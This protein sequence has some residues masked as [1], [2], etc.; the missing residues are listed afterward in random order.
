MVNQ[1]WQSVDA[2]L[3]G[4]SVTETIVWCEIINLN[5]IIFECSKNYI[6]STPATRLKIA[7]NMAD[8]ISVHE[9]GP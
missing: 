9:N 4:V 8:P 6:S 5:T 3:E 2:I 1:F 7:P